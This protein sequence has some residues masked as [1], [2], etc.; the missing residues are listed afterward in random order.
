MDTNAQS[1]SEEP[2][3]NERERPQSVPLEVSFPTREDVWGLD[4]SWLACALGGS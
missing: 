1:A 3:Y 4:G 2:Q